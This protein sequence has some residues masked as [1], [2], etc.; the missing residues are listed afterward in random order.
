MAVDPAVYAQLQ[1][2]PLFAHLSP[3]Q[4]QAVA[5]YCQTV[6]FAPGSPIFAQG[7]PTQGA[8]LITEGRALRLQVDARGREQPLGP[9]NAGE[10]ANADALEREGVEGISLRA[11]APVT[12][13]FLSRTRWL[14]LKQALPGLSLQPP[15]A[16]TLPIAPGPLHFTVEQPH[17]A[18]GAPAIQAALAHDPAMDPV[19]LPPVKTIMRGQRPDERLLHMFR[20][21]WWSLTRLAWI[22]LL[23]VLVGLVLALVLGRSSGLGAVTVLGVSVILAGLTTIYGYTEWRDDALYVSDQR[24]VRV[25]NVIIAFQQAIIE[26]PL[27]RVTGVSWSV[28][29]LDV[30]ARLY[31]YGTV[32]VQTTSESA[33]VSL[34]YVQR[35]EQVQKEI[36][37]VRD[38]VLRERTNATEA[39]VRDQVAS[40]LGLE[41]APIGAPAVASTATRP[42]RYD[43]PPQ[44]PFFARMRFMDSRGDVVYRHH[45][46]TWIGRVAL[47]SLVLTVVL[48]IGSLLLASQQGIDP[49]LVLILMG[50]CLIAGGIWFYLSDWDWRNDLLVLGRETVSIIHRRPLWLQNEVD[51]LRLVQVDNVISDIRGPINTLLNRGRVELSLVG[52]DTRKVFE[53]MYDP[54]GLQL[55]VSRRQA[56]IKRESSQGQLEHQQDATLRM[57]QAYHEMMQ[58]G[59]QP[60]STV[61]V[62]FAPGA[63]QPG[64]AQT[65]PAT[66]FAPTTRPRWASGPTIPSPP[67]GPTQPLPPA[68]GSARPPRIPPAGG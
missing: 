23:M 55:E 5:S 9:M 14:A 39:Q 18:I 40:A 8:M 46:T 63:T 13:I 2:Q 6:R 48:I 30:M 1:R 32:T 62:Q 16:P 7:Q 35:P 10:L 41:G 31:N 65:V 61:P 67:A 4:L 15:T 11:E 36:F 26:I 22:P 49:V 45:W 19:G 53:R 38:R 34:S 59:Q 42:A 54:T 58:G 52:S 28:P 51:T 43:V 33:N 66:P 21:H 29:T 56:E 20:P 27:E 64:S 37:S 60:A 47:P 50:A 68:T 24:V 3:Q 57:L 17:N 12:A 44:G 25:R